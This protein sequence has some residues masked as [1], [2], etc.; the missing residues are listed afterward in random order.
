MSSNPL[1]YIRRRG[2]SPEST[3]I[4]EIGRRKSILLTQECTLRRTLS[5]SVSSPFSPLAITSKRASAGGSSS[6]RGASSSQPSDSLVIGSI[7]SHQ[8][9]VQSTTN[10]SKVIK[11]YD[12]FQFEEDATTTPWN[13]SCPLTLAPLTRPLLNFKV[14]IP[15]LLGNK[16]VSTNE[17]LVEFSNHCH[18]I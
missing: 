2:L 10:P 9:H 18:N 11:K 8:F 14:N 1:I 7:Y 13:V 16:Y 15:K 5:Y 17:H 6:A 12:L 3:P 4:I